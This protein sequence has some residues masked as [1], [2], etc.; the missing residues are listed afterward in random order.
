MADPLTVAQCALSR[1][2]V[3][4]PSLAELW[5]SFESTDGVVVLREAM[6]PETREKITAA[7]AARRAV[8]A[9]QAVT[10]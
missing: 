2:L 5:A 1:L 3:D 8:P 9:K 10:A 6:R 7:E 4:L